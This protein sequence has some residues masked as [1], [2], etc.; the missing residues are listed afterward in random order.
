MYSGF[1]YV[2]IVDLEMTSNDDAVR[3][4]DPAARKS[5][6][7]KPASESLCDRR[8]TVTFDP[9]LINKETLGGSGPFPDTSVAVIEITEEQKERRRKRKRDKHAR[10]K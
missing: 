10:D 4:P 6:L 5:C 1:I 8:R 9:T 3:Q 7:R 2:H